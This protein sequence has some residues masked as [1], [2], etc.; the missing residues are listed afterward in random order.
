MIRIIF[1]NPRYFS[2]GLGILFIVLIASC[3]EP[4]ETAD[5]EALAKTYCASCHAYPEPAILD[6]PTWEKYIL[7]PNGAVYGYL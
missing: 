3:S 7:P 4:G 5:G 2:F 1:F 6:K